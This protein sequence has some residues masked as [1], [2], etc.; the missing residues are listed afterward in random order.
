M[1]DA[2]AINPVLEMLESAEGASDKP[3]RDTCPVEILGC[4]EGK[5]FFLSRL[6]EIR[7]MGTRDFTA[8]GIASLF[9]GQTWWLIENFPRKDK[10]GNVTGFSNQAVSGFLM[11]EGSRKGLF[12]PSTPVRK[13]GVWPF[14]GVLPNGRPGLIVHAG[15]RVWYQGQWQAAGIKIGHALFPTKPEVEEFSDCPSTEEDGQRLL[16][17]INHW[18][19]ERPALDPGLFL[20]SISQAMLGG[21]SPWRAHMIVNGEFGTGKSTLAK[22]ASGVLGAGAHPRSNNYTEAGL[23]QALTGEARC[24][25]LDEAEP[26]ENSN[27]IHSVIQMIRG[28]SDNDGVVALRGSSGGESKGFEITGSALLFSVLRVPMAPQDRSRILPLTLRPLSTDDPGAEVVVKKNVAS[29]TAMSPRFRGRMILRFEQYLETLDFYHAELLR[30]GLKPRAAMQIGSILSGRDVMLHDALPTSDTL[31]L[32][33]ES[34]KE[35]VEDEIDQASTDN[36]GLDCLNYLYTSI[37]DAYIAGHRQ[38]IGQMLYEALNCPDN[39]N[40]RQKNLVIYG[41]RVEYQDGP[42]GKKNYPKTVMIARKHTGLDRI[43]AGTRW[44]DG[45]WVGAMEYL[46]G[47]KISTPQRFGGA[48]TRVVTVPIDLWPK[49]DDDSDG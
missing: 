34:I 11:R 47:P 27:R 14:P 33:V 4:C 35:L 16:T 7:V 12:N 13:V 18:N 5:Y 25:I 2:P 43:Y 39:P 21:A 42:T 3:A 32:E 44:K 37:A 22:L 48:P 45:G 49:A 17:T 30:A 36:E 38:S 8:T 23:R 41:I 20:G 9:D 19:W 40:E 6:G 1:N 31:A 10:D 15:K 46:K 29:M 26:G 28:M 24:M